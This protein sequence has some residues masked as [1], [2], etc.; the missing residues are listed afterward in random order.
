MDDGLDEILGELVREGNADPSFRDEL[1]FPLEDIID[2]RNRLDASLGQRIDYDPDAPM[3]DRPS[4]SGGI[5]FGRA[6]SDRSDTDPTYIPIGDLLG[7]DPDDPD[8]YS[9]EPAGETADAAPQAVTLVSIIEDEADWHGVEEA[10]KEVEEGGLPIDWNAKGEDGATP[11]DWV[12]QWMED[13]ETLGMMTPERFRERAEEFKAL[14][15]V[16]A[17]AF[18]ETQG[19]FAEGSDLSRWRKAKATFQAALERRRHGKFVLLG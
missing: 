10:L 14:E 6:L 5:S 19:R 18:A 2:T 7:V 11:L 8:G 12:I 9:F 4:R 16:V 15:R 13:P 1:P 3:V 17:R